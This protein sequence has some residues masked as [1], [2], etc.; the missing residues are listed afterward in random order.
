MVIGVH[1]IMTVLI[2]ATHIDFLLNDWQIPLNKNAEEYVQGG[3]FIVSLVFNFY[4][5]RVP[6]FFFLFSYLHNVDIHHR[7]DTIIE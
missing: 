4:H 7:E 1:L 2:E 3:H 5:P 6:T